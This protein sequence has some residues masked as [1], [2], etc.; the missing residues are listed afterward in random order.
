MA[1]PDHD[2]WNSVSNLRDN[3]VGGLPAIAFDYVMKGPESPENFHAVALILQSKYVF[4][5]DWWAY[6]NSG[7]GPAI[8]K[9]ANSVVASIAIN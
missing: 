9:V 5:M 7:Y 4:V 2:F 6:A 1:A 3:A 8:D